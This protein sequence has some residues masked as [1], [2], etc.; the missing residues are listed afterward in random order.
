MCEL[1]RVKN[2]RRD[3]RGERVERRVIDQIRPRAQIGHEKIPL[4]ACGRHIAHGGEDRPTFTPRNERRW[5]TG[6]GRIGHFRK[7]RVCRERLAGLL[8][9]PV[10]AAE[11]GQGHGSDAA[12]RGRRGFLVFGNGR[13][14][15]PINDLGLLAG[16]E[17]CVSGRF[18]ASNGGVVNKPLPAGR[19]DTIDGEAKSRRARGQRR[20]GF[21]VCENVFPAYKLGVDFPDDLG[22]GLPQSFG[23]DQPIEFVFLPAGSAAGDRPA[24]ERKN[25]EKPAMSLAAG[26][27]T[28][29]TWPL[30]GLTSRTAGCTAQALRLPSDAPYFARGLPPGPADFASGLSSLPANNASGSS[31]SSHANLL[32]E[33][34]VCEFAWLPP[35]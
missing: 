22:R 31:T 34:I 16:A 15:I 28:D 9:V 26:P 25:D 14:E 33:A 10:T 35:G 17:S 7:V 32:K 20:I 1:G 8:Q 13:L 11:T 4:A 3:E 18:V 19:D 12:H 5:H 24:D 29:R 21:C 6:N 23:N 30:F 2:A 27:R